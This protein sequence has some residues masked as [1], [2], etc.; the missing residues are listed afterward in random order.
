MEL[1]GS[2]SGWFRLVCIG[3][4]WGPECLEM[5]IARQNVLL[6]HMEPSKIGSDLANANFNANA[7]ANS[8]AN[9]IWSDFCLRFAKICSPLE[10]EAHF[11]KPTLSNRPSKI[12]FL[13]HW[14]LQMRTHWAIF[15]VLM[16]LKLFFSPLFRFSRPSKFWKIVG[17]TYY[18][19]TWSRP[20]SDPTLQMQILMQTQVQIRMQMQFEVIFASVWVR[21]KRFLPPFGS[22]FALFFDRLGSASAHAIANES[23]IVIWLGRPADCQYMYI[24]R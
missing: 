10:R 3:F 11:W 6:S 17:K 8:N 19:R 18:F 4:R 13:E 14:R 5:Q 15:S 22:V 9:A 20:K 21:L 23:A 12:H 16:A 7:S 1:C 2:D 24:D